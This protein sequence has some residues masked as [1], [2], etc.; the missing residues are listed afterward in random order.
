MVSTEQI[1]LALSS[2][3]FI[4]RQ[5]VQAAIKR[6][7]QRHKCS[8]CHE[9]T[10]VILSEITS[11]HAGAI[12]SQSGWVKLIEQQQKNSHNHSHYFRI[13]AKCEKGR[14]GLH[15]YAGDA[16]DG[17]KEALIRKI[18]MI[19]R[20]APDVVVGVDDVGWLSKSIL[21]IGVDDIF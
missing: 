12:L 7:S 9:H 11:S 15:T 20:A 5:M 2:I 16:T 10:E 19:F 8:H 4:G 13:C 21:L 17:S 3:P 6:C 1:L 18:T 14:L